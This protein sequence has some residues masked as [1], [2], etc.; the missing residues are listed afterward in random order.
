MIFKTAIMMG[1]EG[2]CRVVWG[3][4]FGWARGM[5]KFPLQCQGWILNLLHFL[6]AFEV[7]RLAT[8]NNV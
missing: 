7:K 8:L 5:W 3:V 4:F 1:R 2:K 6:N